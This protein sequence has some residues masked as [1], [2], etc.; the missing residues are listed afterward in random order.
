MQ[1]RDFD[2]ASETL[3]EYCS[4]MARAILALRAEIPTEHARPF[5]AAIVRAV[6]A[7]PFD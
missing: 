2:P 5:A 3:A 7:E 1:P 6:K 4:D